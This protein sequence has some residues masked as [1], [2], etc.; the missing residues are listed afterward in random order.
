LAVSAMIGTLAVIA[1]LAG[2]DRARRLVAV[3]L[4]HVAIHQ[5]HVVAR[6]RDRFDG[7]PPV[8]GDFGRT[9]ELLQHAR[10]HALIDQVVLDQQHAP[11][12]RKRQGG[13]GFVE[14]FT[15]VRRAPL[16][17]SAMAIF[18]VNQNTLPRPASLSTPMAPPISSAN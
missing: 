5:Y 9:T 14:C 4:R 15:L 17:R 11:G 10:R 13:G 18:T 8:R 2:A 6:A 3:H 7:L 12:W 1:L 16:A